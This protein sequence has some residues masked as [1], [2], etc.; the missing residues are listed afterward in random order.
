LQR[1]AVLFRDR[2]KRPERALRAFERMLEIDEKNL[3]AAEGLIPLYGAGD[4]AKWI[5]VLAIQLEHTGDPALRQAR[6]K[7]LGELQEPL[8][9]LERLYTGREQHAE[10]VVIC[11]RRMQLATDPEA[12]K[13]AHLKIAQLAEQRLHDDGVAISAYAALLEEDPREKAAFEALDRL[14]R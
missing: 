2:L 11:Q 13:R 5:R 6:L 7:R 12:R 4:A 3:V 8:E 10:L 9:A 1:M 14:Y